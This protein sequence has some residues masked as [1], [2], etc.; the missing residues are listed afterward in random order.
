MPFY[1]VYGREV[2]AEVS[3]ATAWMVV[4]V[5]GADRQSALAG[6]GEGPLGVLTL[7]WPEGIASAAGTLA[8]ILVS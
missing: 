7:P 2:R 8:E 1:M 3:M 5:V 4:K 6:A